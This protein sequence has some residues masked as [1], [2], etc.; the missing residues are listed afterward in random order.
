ME[1]DVLQWFY[2]VSQS[3]RTLNSEKITLV[4]VIKGTITSEVNISFVMVK[5]ESECES[6][7]CC[8]PVSKD[9]TGRMFWWI[10]GFSVEFYYCRLL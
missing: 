1:G 5:L 3:R 2:S 10:S 6:Q 7:R 9:N 4:K 8:R